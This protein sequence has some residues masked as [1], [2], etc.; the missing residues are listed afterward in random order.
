MEKTKNKDA[1][2]QL[3]KQLTKQEEIES[4]IRRLFIAIDEL[5]S[6]VEKVNNDNA[7]GKALQE[8]DAEKLLSLSDFLNSLPATL[9]YMRTRINENLTT[10]NDLLY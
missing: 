7:T 5:E 1:T 6:F 9:E 2:G 8:K 4:S 3:K 10:L